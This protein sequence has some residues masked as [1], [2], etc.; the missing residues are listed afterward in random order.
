MCFCDFGAYMGRAGRKEIAAMH[1]R[2]CVSMISVLTWGGR[3]EGNHRNAHTYV[4]FCDSGAHMG[5]AGRKEI[6]GMHI[7]MCVSVIPVLTW[8]GPGGKETQKCT[9]VCMFL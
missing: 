9:Y 3:V 6:T 8:R 1:I 2:M 5:S 7:R 4:C